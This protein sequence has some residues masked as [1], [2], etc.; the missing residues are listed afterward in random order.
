MYKFLTTYLPKNLA[1]IAI[2]LWY[3][4]LIAVN[5]YCG[6]AAAQGAFQYVGW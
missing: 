2:A 4:F 1:N 6:I 5:L 3:F